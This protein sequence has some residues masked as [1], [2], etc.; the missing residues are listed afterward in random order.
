MVGLSQLFCLLGID[1]RGFHVEQELLKGIPGADVVVLLLLFIIEELLQC[2]CILDFFLSSLL[3]CNL[4]F[5]VSL[6]EFICV[7]GGGGQDAFLVDF[8]CDN[9]VRLTCRSLRDALNC[10]LT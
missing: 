2:L 6:V 4:N 10:K 9:N 7:L 8:K 3:L 5:D 1:L